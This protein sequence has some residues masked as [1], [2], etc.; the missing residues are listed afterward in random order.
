MMLDTLEH[1]ACALADALA[2]NDRDF[3]AAGV[4][5]HVAVS[6][7]AHTGT[8]SYIDFYEPKADS[9]HQKLFFANRKQA[10]IPLVEDLHRAL[11]ATLPSLG[12]LTWSLQTT[13]PKPGKNG[14]MLQLWGWKT[15]H[16]SAKKVGQR[17][18][19]IA[20]R[21]APVRTGLRTFCVQPNQQT[22]WELRAAGP[23]DAL[24]AWHVMRFSSY[25]PTYERLESVYV[26]VV[27]THRRPAIL[28]ALR[29]HHHQE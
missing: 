8:T 4:D 3:A 6:V 16:S 1:R 26:D 14:F 22:S 17:L 21:M 10:L 13:L 20:Q 24:L 18:R 9:A 29:A 5:R 28:A 7:A 23:E 12:P 25:A 27:E 11:E 2:A 19:T 15:P